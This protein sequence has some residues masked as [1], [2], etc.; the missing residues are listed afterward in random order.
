MARGT[1]IVGRGGYEVLAI[2]DFLTWLVFLWM[3]AL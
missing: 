3:F 2:F 1:Q